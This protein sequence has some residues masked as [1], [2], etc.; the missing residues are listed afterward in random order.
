MPRLA[1]SRRN[2][3]TQR[4]SLGGSSFLLP[5]QQQLVRFVNGRGREVRSCCSESM[6]LMQHTMSKL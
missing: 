1:G 4:C 2:Q 3:H 5:L 6:L